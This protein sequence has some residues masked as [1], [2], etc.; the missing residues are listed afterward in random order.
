VPR[1]DDLAGDVDQQRRVG[2]ADLKRDHLDLTLQKFLQRKLDRH[3]RSR[4]RFRTERS[5][6]QIEQTA[7][8]RRARQ[9]LGCG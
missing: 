1:R 7:A 2:R 3:P 6:Q 5:E 8:Q 9:A 4:R